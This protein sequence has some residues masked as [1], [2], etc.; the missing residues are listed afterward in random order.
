MRDHIERLLI[1]YRSQGILVDAN[2]LLLYVVGLVETAR[3]ERFKRTATFTVADFE[4]LVRLLEDFD[5]VIT[6]PSVLTEVSNFLGQLPKGPQRTGLLVLR[7][8]VQTFTEEYR[9]AT[10][11]C[12]HPHFIS[13]RLTDAGIIEVAADSYLVLTDDL[14][15]YHFM[16]N[17][18]QPVLNFNHLREA[19]W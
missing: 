13:F 19:N 14:P 11:I 15:L 1:D 12:A 16:A 5:R 4:L 9:R 7:E 10:Q 18:E 2:L 3:I 17:K 6:T 8:L